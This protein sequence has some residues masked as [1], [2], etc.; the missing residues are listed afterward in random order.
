MLPRFPKG[1][2][3]ISWIKETF[4]TETG[5]IYEPVLEEIRIRVT[6][7]KSGQSMQGLPSTRDKT[8][9]TIK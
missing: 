6:H 8:G 1:M 5:K 9:E 2:E 4:R 7:Q 3:G